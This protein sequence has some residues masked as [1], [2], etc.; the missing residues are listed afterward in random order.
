MIYQSHKFFS[1]FTLLVVAALMIL[2][3]SVTAQSKDTWTSVQTKNF[4]LI[5]NASDKDIRVVGNRL[6]QV[7]RGLWLAV[8]HHETYFTGAHDSNRF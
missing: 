4:R 6:E 1:R 2:G 5:G 8:S 7:S 3:A